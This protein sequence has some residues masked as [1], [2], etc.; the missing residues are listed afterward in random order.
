MIS[1]RGVRLMGKLIV[2]DQITV[3]LWL[4]HRPATN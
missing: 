4:R 1:N 2:S 3:V